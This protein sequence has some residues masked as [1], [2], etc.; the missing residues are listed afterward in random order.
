MVAHEGH[1]RP[2][3]LPSDL[4]NQQRRSADAFELAG[5]GD[6]LESGSLRYAD[7]VTAA[8]E[9]VLRHLVLEQD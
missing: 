2:P 1:W 5:R 8:T 4:A 3:A 9:A 7:A 6:G